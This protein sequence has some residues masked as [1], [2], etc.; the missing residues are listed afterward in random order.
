MSDTR[1]THCTL[2]FHFLFFKQA[3]LS[4]TRCTCESIKHLLLVIFKRLPQRHPQQ[5]SLSCQRQANSA[6]PPLLSL[7]IPQS[8]PCLCTAFTSRHYDLQPH[9]FLRWLQTRCDGDG[10]EFMLKLRKSSSRVF[11]SGIQCDTTTAPY[12]VILAATSA[13]VE[14]TGCHG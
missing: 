3:K 12:H 4:L 6:P 14:A 13:S 9:G 7:F 2:I 10:E 5:S 11:R 1:G 8:W